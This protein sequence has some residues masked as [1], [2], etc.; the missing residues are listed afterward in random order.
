MVVVLLGFGRFILHRGGGLDPGD[1]FGH[2]PGATT[3]L[4]GPVR[5]RRMAHVV[6]MPLILCPSR[7]RVARRA[8]NIGA[9]GS[10]SWV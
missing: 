8:F 2:Y 5:Y 1:V 10:I 9:E 6:S 4:M 7:I 3:G